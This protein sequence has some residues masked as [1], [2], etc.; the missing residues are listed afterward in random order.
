MNK[1]LFLDRDGVINVEKNDGSFT[2]KADD[3]ILLPDVTKV[4]LTAKQKNYLLI[5]ITNQSGVGQGIYQHENIALVHQKLQ[6]LLA[7]KKITLDEI[8]YCP[9]HPTSS[10]CLC[11][12]PDSLLIEK[13]IARFN[14]DPKQSIFVGDKERDSQA[15]KKA[16]I[17]TVIQIES[18]ASL[19]PIV[20]LLK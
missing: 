12:K 15:A 19:L 17:K 13:A 3:F 2:Y 6:H 10:N 4:L 20:N 8:Y 1:A 9:H 7:E 18:N 11:R 16:G 5:V 14:I